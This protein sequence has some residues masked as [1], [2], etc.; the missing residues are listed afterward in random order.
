MGAIAAGGI[1]AGIYTSNLPEVMPCALSS[2]GPGLL[3][4]R[5]FLALRR[6]CTP[7]MRKSFRTSREKVVSVT[8]SVTR[9]YSPVESASRSPFCGGLGLCLFLVGG[10]GDNRSRRDSFEVL[11]GYADAAWRLRHPVISGSKR[12]AVEN[13]NKMQHF[14]LSKSTSN[15]IPEIKML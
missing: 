6:S 2:V 14:P 3:G 12:V 5:F 13:S 15:V 9:V 4:A 10:V 11:W 1:A 7:P 8:D